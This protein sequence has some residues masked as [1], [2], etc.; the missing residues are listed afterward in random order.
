MFSPPPAMPDATSYGASAATP[1]P[2]I[3]SPPQ[4][5]PHTQERSYTLG[6]D[7]YGYGQQ[8]QQQ[9]D[10]SSNPYIGGS[11]SPPQR[12]Y[13]TSPQQQYASP[14][15]Q[16]S[17]P[18]YPPALDTGAGQYDSHYATQ[19]QQQPTSPTSPV[20]GPRPP[21]GRQQTGMSEEAPPGYDTGTA[22][23]TGNWGKQGGR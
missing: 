15:Q 17:D 13:T 18:R 12:Q 11:T 2:Y 16:Y 5:Q 1:N 21:P 10:Y 14:P 22:G 6:G 23:V 4:Q 20:R 9:H 3:S 7:G 8:Q 19:Q